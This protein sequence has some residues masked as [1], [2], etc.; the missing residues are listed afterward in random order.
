MNKIVKRLTLT[1]LALTSFVGLATLQPTTANASKIHYVKWNKPMKHHQVAVN[2]RK[3]SWKGYTLKKVSKKH[4]RFRTAAKLSSQK[5]QVHSL[6]TLRHAKIDHS[7][8]YAVRI[9]KKGKTIW[10][11]RHYL[12]SWVKTSST[13]KKTSGKASSQTTTPANKAKNT[14]KKSGSKATNTGKFYVKS[15]KHITW[16]QWLNLPAF[17]ADGN[18]IPLYNVDNVPYDEDGFPYVSNKMGSA[19]PIEVTQ[20]KSEF[21]AAA[22]AAIPDKSNTYYL[23]DKN[24]LYHPTNPEVG[25]A[26]RN[27]IPNDTSIANAKQTQEQAGNRVAEISSNFTLANMTVGASK[28]AQMWSS[29]YGNLKLSEAARNTFTIQP[30]DSAIVSVPSR[31]TTGKFTITAKRAGTTT[32]KVTSVNNPNLFETFTIN[33]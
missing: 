9:G 23:S 25:Q 24:A 4:Y 29:V 6:T 22:Y 32:I 3:A 2:G 8:Y 11:N 27:K 15:T 13:S 7:I 1:T 16:T 20:I 19:S 21:T 31:T 18:G 28:T 10:V 30:A 14:S 12:T 33:V 5:Y 26:I 17:G